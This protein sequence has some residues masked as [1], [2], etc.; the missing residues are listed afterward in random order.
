[1]RYFICHKKKKEEAE[2]E[3]MDGIPVE[4]LSPLFKHCQPL[5]TEKEDLQILDFEIVE[6]L[7]LLQAEY[8]KRFQDAKYC[9][10]KNDLIKGIHH[11][12]RSN[13]I[14]KRIIQLEKRHTEIQ[15]ELEMI[16]MMHP[17]IEPLR[18]RIPKQ[19]TV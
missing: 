2:P 1:M 12:N 5:P 7:H 13:E 10:T 15:H 8:N 17:A 16:L 14:K 3:F 19:R 11:M 4:I 18:I 6:Q 9:I